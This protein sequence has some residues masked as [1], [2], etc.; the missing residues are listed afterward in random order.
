MLLFSCIN[1]VFILTRLIK[2]GKKSFSKHA[3]MHD[4]KLIYNRNQNS[5]ENRFGFWRGRELQVRR[6]SS[7]LYIYCRFIYVMH[8]YI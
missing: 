2:K 4:N 8:V 6:F 1:K 7:L 5:Q 3:C